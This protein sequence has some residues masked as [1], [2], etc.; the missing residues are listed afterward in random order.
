LETREP[1][2]IKYTM[3]ETLGQ[4]I[5]NCLKK[6]ILENKIKAGQKIN[7][8]EIADSFKV[9]RTPVREALVRLE[10]EGFTKIISHREI[11]VKEC[12]YEELTQLFQ[13]MGILDSLAA[14]L[15]IDNIDSKEFIKIEK[16]MG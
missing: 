10:A 12:S 11:V 7:E 4:S 3:P 1:K 14:T 2:P 6:A 16:M 9:S 13:V 8:K 5:Y 15:V